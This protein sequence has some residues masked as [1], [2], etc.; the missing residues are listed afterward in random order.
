VWC[1]LESLSCSRLSHDLESQILLCSYLIKVSWTVVMYMASIELPFCPTWSVP[2]SSDLTNQKKGGFCWSS[3][4]ERPKFFRV[5]HDSALV[6]KKLLYFICDGSFAL[7]VLEPSRASGRCHAL[8]PAGT[9][10]YACGFDGCHAHHHLRSR[11]H[12]WME[13]LVVSIDSRCAIAFSLVAAVQ[14]IQYRCT[15]NCRFLSWKPPGRR[16]KRT[17]N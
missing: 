17:C 7:F 9:M 1:V 4:T 15:W 8:P 5:R 11:S 12:W 2:W 6:S 10:H 3:H 13:L 16:Y 14:I